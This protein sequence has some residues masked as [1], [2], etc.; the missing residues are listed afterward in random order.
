MSF[1]SH[2]ANSP[3]KRFSVNFQT[4]PN[5]DH[6]PGGLWLSDDSEFGWFDLLTELTHKGTSEWSD[7][8]LVWKCR[9]DFSIS[10]KEVDRVLILRSPD[11]LEEFG[12]IYR[13]GSRRGCQIKGAPG[14]GLHIDWCRLKVD[15]KGIVIT[16][17]YSELAKDDSSFHWYKGFDSASGCFWDISCLLSEG[18]PYPAWT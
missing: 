1:F 13:E 18:G 8:D 4:P 17:F 3:Y 10:P 6:K 7:A 9:Y 12:V 16:P 5:T 2:N 15:F 14:F 11:D